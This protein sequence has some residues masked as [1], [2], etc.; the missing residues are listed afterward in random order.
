M[1]KQNKV[2]TVLLILS[3]IA[4]LALGL[5]GCGN[6]AESTNDQQNEAQQAQNQSAE[7]LELEGKVL[8]IY[9]GAGM[10]KP[11]EKIAQ[12]FKDT[13]GCDMEVVYANA[14]QIQT[15]ID[16]TQEGDLFIAG[17]AEELARVQQYIADSKDLVKHIPVLAVKAD[18]PMGINGLN[19]L[20]KEGVEV[21]LGDADAT[22]IGKLSNK[23]MTDL[24]IMDK[25]KVAARTTTA[26]EIFN[27]LALDECDAIIVWKE[28]VNGNDVE[29][30][31]TTDLD[32]YIKVVPA[33]KLTFSKD[34]DTVDAFLEFLDS[35]TAKNIWTEFGYEI[36]S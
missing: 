3:L 31:N 36:V 28:N 4:A 24:G 2:L 26:P 29:I 14:A 34:K 19:D 18:N 12:S 32:K 1:R 5:S 35:D 10:T 11:F 9:C 22:P 16:T 21:V 7:T 30:V 20:T 27:A 8:Q 25:I 15:Q 13:T 6:K 23:A 33:A 17:S